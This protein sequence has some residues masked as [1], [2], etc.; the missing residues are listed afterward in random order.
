M[1]ARPAMNNSQPGPLNS[2][3]QSSVPLAWDLT[4]RDRATSFPTFRQKPRSWPANK[5]RIVRLTEWPHT[6]F[7]VELRP[8]G[9]QDPTR[10]GVDQPSR[11]NPFSVLAV[12][13]EVAK[14]IPDLIA[15]LR[16]RPDHLDVI[17]I[18]KHLA[19]APPHAIAQRGVDVPRRG[20]REA[21][22]PTGQRSRVLGLDEQVHVRALQ[23]DVHDP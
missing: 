5:Q 3:R 6:R 20:D 21:L 15:S 18:G 13:S 16:W 7:A 14:Y 12:L 9:K 1:A 23:R 4:R 8:V 22:H 19:A 10:E 17:P 11:R 2:R